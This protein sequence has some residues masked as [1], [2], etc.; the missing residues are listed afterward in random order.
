LN[1]RL[2]YLD[3]STI[4]IRIGEIGD[5]VTDPKAVPDVVNPQLSIDM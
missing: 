2:G 4:S 5:P 3:A 1:L